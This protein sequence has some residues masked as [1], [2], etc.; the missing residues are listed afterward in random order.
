MLDPNTEGYREAAKLEIEYFAQKTLDV[1]T[2]TSLPY[3]YDPIAYAQPN[4]WIYKQTIEK[5]YEGFADKLRAQFGDTA[6]IVDLGCGPGGSSLW[7]AL[8]GYDVLGVDYSPERIRAATEIAKRYQSEIE[9]AGGALRYVCGDFHEI[10]PGQIDAVISFLT[11]HHVPNPKAL[12]E[13]YLKY[14]PEN[15]LFLIFD[16]FN[17]SNFAYLARGIMVASFPPGTCGTPWRQRQKDFAIR[18]AILIGF[19]PSP[20]HENPLEGIGQWDTMPAF[21]ELFSTYQL[22]NADPLR[23][24]L[25]VQKIKPKHQFWVI[26]WSIVNRSIECISNHFSMDLGLEKTIIAEVRDRRLNS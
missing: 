4:R 10:D 3:Y 14:L 8:K 21:K 24:L 22:R 23:L 26:P 1:T 19:Y 7:F 16:Q 18:L 11:F 20:E 2:S 5:V 13:R 25:T 17:K 9:K 12:I 15:G 6:R